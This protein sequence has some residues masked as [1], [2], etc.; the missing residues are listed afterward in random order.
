MPP[1]PEDA[2]HRSLSTH[3]GGDCGGGGPWAEAGAG[4]SAQALA[5]LAPGLAQRLVGSPLERHLARTGVDMV[6]LRSTLALSAPERL[7]RLEA[8]LRTDRFTG[9]LRELTEARLR[10]VIIGG[11]A[12]V[13]YGSS[14][15]TEDCDVCHARTPENL[16]AAAQ[17][18]GALGATF[19]RLPVQAPAR[20]EAAV[21][22]TEPDFVF[23][24][25]HGKFDLIGC[26]SGVGTYAE[27]SIGAVEATLAG[28]RHRVL[29]LPLLLQSKRSTGRSRDLLVAAELAAIQRIHRWAAVCDRAG[30]SPQGA[31]SA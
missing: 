28:A 17:L 26:F 13:L 7:A 18:L 11:L 14:L 27:A 23:T 30:V 15:L 22:A 1:T 5:P 16:A 25:V 31:P 21:L 8:Q 3:V 20:I 24:T 2:R 10:Y 6:A 12:G 9:I 29:A 4:L 19:R